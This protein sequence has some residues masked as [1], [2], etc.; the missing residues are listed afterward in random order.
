[1]NDKTKNI[2]Q[3][4]TSLSKYNDSPELTNLYRGD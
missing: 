2:E 3:F 1:M 4:L